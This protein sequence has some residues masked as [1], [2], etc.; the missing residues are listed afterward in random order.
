MTRS[1]LSVFLVLCFHS[2]EGSESDRLASLL[3]AEWADRLREDP[4][5][6]TLAGH[7]EYDDRLPDLSPEAA[8][9]RYEKN[10][11]WLRQL[12]G[13]DREGLSPQ[14]R[15]SGALFEFDLQ[16]RLKRYE[17]GTARIPFTSDTGFYS[18]LTYAFSRMPL[19]DQ[20][21]FER[22]V[23]RLHAIP[24]YLM[25]NQ[26]WMVR[27]LESGFT[28]PRIVMVG[29][30]EILKGLGE[31]PVEAHPLYTPFATQVHRLPDSKRANFLRRAEVAVRDV[32][33]PAFRSLAD[34]VSDDYTPKC[35]ES[36]GLSELSE[37]KEYYRFLVSYFTT[38]DL[39]PEQ[40]H[41]IGLAE[42][43]RI[44]R[45][46]E[47]VIESIGYENG[48]S[49]FLQFLRSDEQ[50]YASSAEELLKEASWLSKRIDG[51]LPAYFGRL[52]R[53]P[54][55]VEAVPDHLAPNYTTGR[56]S[57]G[58]PGGDRGGYYWVNTYALE[59]RPLY[60]LP[61]LTLHE[62]VPGHHLQIALA[63]EIEGLPEFR[64]HFY[65]NAFGEGWALYA[66]KLGK[67]MGVYRTAYE[68]FG[69]LTYEMWRAGRL[70]VDT[71]IHY[72]GW[73]RDQAVAL[74]VENSALSRHNIE[75]EIDRYISW[76]GQALSYKMGELT[77]WR[78]R[79]EAEKALGERF[80]LRSFHDTILKNGGVTMAVL[81]QQ[82]ANYIKESRASE[83]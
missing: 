31:G 29:V 11:E 65:P 81:E 54:Y 63:Q 75:T 73:S 9:R 17:F 8:K 25:Q 35:R 26:D 1:F 80:D 52:P 37:G 20:A 39:E 22:Y 48:F 42:V 83:Q 15:I 38:L 6:A 16:S 43:A 14:G 66:E 32:V 40:V 71:G 33:L 68:E 19:R 10:Q 51:I 47:V 12:Q 49:Q 60:A 69:R 62:A 70:V 13:I 59:K 23:E 53:M 3:S 45:E 57:P 24:V 82:V 58:V 78:L 44:R 76:P 18:T 5:E 77:I 28:M 72:L 61:A 2:V 56:Y 4:L 67:E 50:F 34:F 30:G 55:G 27:G 41:E 36:I 64:Q 21:G 7:S 79:A 46:M 74:L